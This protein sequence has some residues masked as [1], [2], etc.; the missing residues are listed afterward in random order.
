MSSATR[1]IRQRLGYRQQMAAWF[2]AT[3][4]LFNTAAHFYFGVIPFQP[5]VLDLSNQEALTALEWLTHATKNN[6]APIMPQTA[7]RKV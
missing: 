6:S 4:T 1:T 3:Q 2:A 5:G 7:E